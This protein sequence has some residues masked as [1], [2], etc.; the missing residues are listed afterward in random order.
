MVLGYRYCLPTLDCRVCTPHGK[1]WGAGFEY[2]A[3]S[4][5]FLNEREFNMDRVATLEEFEKIRRRISEAL[6]RYVRLAPLSELG[7]LSGR[8]VSKNLRDFEW[9]RI[10]I[11]QISK[12][13]NEILAAEGVHLTTV[14]FAVFCPGRRE[15]SH[16]AIHLEPVALMTEESMARHKKKRCVRCGKV[17]SPPKPDPVV[18]E[19]FT[20]R[21]SAWPVGQDLVLMEETHRVL[22]SE[23]FMQV[24]E[25]YNIT[26]IRFIPC[27]RFEGE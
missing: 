19:G 20:V 6:G 9:G 16:L 25:K 3:F 26:G 22:A 15:N 12:K 10:Y 7:P 21:R 24:V 17:I 14:E 11:P 13:A 8:A 5:E 27:G 23:R 4:F 18:P 1:G 2:P